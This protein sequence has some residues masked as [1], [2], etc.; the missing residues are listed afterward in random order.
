M[1]EYRKQSVIILAQIL[2]FY[3]FPLLAKP[4]GAMGMVLAMI[5]LTFVLGWRMGSTPGRKSRFLYPLFVA[6][7][8]IPSV[9]LFY[10]ESAMVQAVWYL[11]VS[12]VGV[13]T[14]S[15]FGK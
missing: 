1:R 12:A 7:I 14:G 8:F 11:V 5:L 9:Y 3:L 6:T 4:L 10:N 13:A 15:A 2:L